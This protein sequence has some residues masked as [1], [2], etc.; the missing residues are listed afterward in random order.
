[1]F[2]LFGQGTEADKPYDTI[3]GITA[4]NE[5]EAAAQLRELVGGR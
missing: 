3:I 2:Y 1:M 5:A 4:A